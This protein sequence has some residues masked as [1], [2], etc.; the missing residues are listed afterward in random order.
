MGIVLALLICLIG[1]SEGE[2]KLRGR[3][4]LEKYMSEIAKH[5]DIKNLHLVRPSEDLPLPVEE[6]F[7]EEEIESA[8]SPV[9]NE[10]QRRYEEIFSKHWEEMQALKKSLGWTDKEE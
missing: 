7:M 5:G 1:V 4:K 2:G 9:L 3:A 10:A 8:P 6:E